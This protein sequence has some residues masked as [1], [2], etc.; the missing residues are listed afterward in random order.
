MLFFT[1]SVLFFETTEREAI[2]CLSCPEG[3]LE[4]EE[5]LPDSKPQGK[6]A[7]DTIAGTTKIRRGKPHNKRASGYHHRNESLML[8]SQ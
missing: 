4:K 3:R 6:G 7:E 1:L 2:S 5:T 8:T